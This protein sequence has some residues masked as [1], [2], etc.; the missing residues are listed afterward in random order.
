MPTSWLFLPSERELNEGTLPSKPRTIAIVRSSVKLTVDVKWPVDVGLHGEAAVG[1]IQ[2]AEMLLERPRFYQSCS[3]KPEQR[4]GR[5]CCRNMMLLTGCPNSRSSAAV[6][7]ATHVVDSS[8]VRGGIASHLG[9][10]DFV[11]PCWP[12]FRI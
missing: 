8:R 1:G 10:E 3:S 11:P 5:C 9:A 2:I 12:P 7:S 4:A 6:A